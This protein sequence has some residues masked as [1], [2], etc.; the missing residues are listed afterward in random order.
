MTL[1]PV[2]SPSGASVVG[3]DG[4]TVSGTYEP[5]HGYV[6][7]PSPYTDV[8]DPEGDVLADPDGVIVSELVLGNPNLVAGL[9]PFFLVSIEVF[10]PATAVV[11]DYGWGA[12]PWGDISLEAWAT[13]ETQTIRVSD[14]GY[15]SD[16][17]VTAYPPELLG[18]LTFDARIPLAP[19]QTGVVYGWGELSIA[20][21]DR[22][23]DS[24]IQA[25]NIEG[26]TVSIRY[27]IK[28]WDDTRGIFIDPPLDDTYEVFTG[29][30]GPWTLSEFML[31][32]PLRDASYWTERRL[33]RT[34]YAGTGTYEGDAELAG[35]AKPKARGRAYNVPLTLVDRVNGIYQYNDGPGEVVALYEGGATTL[36]FAS[37]TTNL[38]S[39]STASGYYRTDNSRGLI[40]LGNDPAD[41]AVLTAD[42]IGHF[43]TAGEKLIAADIARYLLSEDIGLPAAL[44]DTDSFDQAAVDYPY[45][46]GFFWGPD[47]ATD[48]ATAVGS[49][50]ASFG[51]KIAPSTSGALFCLPMQAIQP[52]DVSAV[53]FS[54]AAIVRVEP[55]PMSPEISP[56]PYRF[57]CA[58]QHNYTVQQEAGLLGSASASRRQFVQT[59]D[60]YA[61]YYNAATELAYANGNDAAPF[62]GGLSDE[63]DAQ[64]VVDRTGE[65]FGVRRWVFD[66]TLPL[67]EGFWVEFGQIVDLTY[68]IHAFQT[69]APAIVVGRSL[70]VSDLTVTLTVLA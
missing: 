43:P 37:D 7:V 4:L 30:A 27:G 57:R 5:L 66:V 54:T 34:F 15:R 14:L 35:T 44:L 18:G 23:Y 21:V 59:A 68:P 11:T 70:N 8:V 38:Y 47:D 51:A 22:K 29:V 24:V 36:A 50:V 58:Y 2:T 55:R 45:E 31:R 52:A 1:A 42:V 69:G 41:N 3:P 12:T 25:W 13:E 56:P 65:L 19:G 28:V 60:R 48:G 16:S 26:R 61:A 53:S 39:G 10:R 32:I 62:G 64:E 33:Q 40:Q 17:P 46:A 9:R 49:V 20:N 6:G 63:T 67:L